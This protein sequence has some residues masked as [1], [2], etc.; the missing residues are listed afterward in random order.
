MK[1]RV[2]KRAAM[3][4]SLAAVFPISV[5]AAELKGQ[6]YFD[7]YPYTG[8]ELIFIQNGEQVAVTQTDEFGNYLLQD[9]DPGRYRVRVRS[10]DFNTSQSFADVQDGANIHN[11]WLLNEVDVPVSAKYELSG[12][13][14][15]LNGRV[16]PN[17]EIRLN[18]NDGFGTTSIYTDEDGYYS[19]SIE[20][21]SYSVE[22]S[23]YGDV[24]IDGDGELDQYLNL[25]ENGEQLNLSAPTTRDFVFQVKEVDIKAVYDGQSFSAW[26]VS[27][28][29]YS[30]SLDNDFISGYVYSYVYDTID[31]HAIL[32]A[33]Q[34]I[35]GSL[36]PFDDSL[37]VTSLGALVTTSDATLDSFEVELEDTGYIVDVAITDIDGEP[38]LGACAS[39]RNYDSTINIY[40]CANDQENIA[41]FHVP[42]ANYT[43]NSSN[44][45]RDWMASNA[46]YSHLNLNTIGVLDLSEQPNE[47][48]SLSHDLVLPIYKQRGRVV[49][50]EGN[51]IEGAQISYDVYSWFE[52]N[53]FDSYVNARLDGLS[54]NANGI[55][56]VYV[57]FELD[58]MYVSAPSDSGLMGGYFEYSSSRKDKLFNIVLSES[59]SEEPDPEPGEGVFV[60]GKV[61]NI[62]GEP[63]SMNVNVYDINYDIVNSTTSDSNGNYSVSVPDNSEYRIDVSYKNYW[64]AASA[65]SSNYVNS[66]SELFTV[67]G[68]SKQDIVIPVL[69]SSFR[70]VGADGVAIPGMQIEVRGNSYPSGIDYSYSRHTGV[71]NNEGLVTIA[72][73]IQYVSTTINN[74]PLP[75]YEDMYRESEESTNTHTD[76]IYLGT[77]VVP[78]SDEDGI[79][80]FYEERFGYDDAS[81]DYDGDGLTFLEEYQNMSSPFSADTDTDGILDVDDTNSQLFKGIGDVDTSLD[82]D[83]DGWGDVYEIMQGLDPFDENIKPLLLSN[84][85]LNNEGLESCLIDSIDEW[86]NRDAV[87]A[88]EIGS[89]SCWDFDLSSLSGIENFVNLSTLRLSY[90][91]EIEDFSALSKLK[92]LVSLSITQ[93]GLS[94]LDFLSELKALN[95][96]NITLDEYAGDL[97]GLAELN[98]LQ[99]LAITLGSYDGDLS[100]IGT[101]GQL[102][103]LRLA[104]GYNVE[105]IDFLFNLTELKSLTLQ[106]FPLISEELEKLAS[107]EKLENLMLGST[108]VTS[109]D[110]IV[111]LQNLR[112]FD[113]C[114]QSGVDFSVLSQ[115]PSLKWLYISNSGL[116]D[117]SFL[118]GMELEGLG[119]WDNEIVD[120]SPLA[121]MESLLY[122]YLGGN[123]DLT[124]LEDADWELNYFSLE[125]Y[126]PFTELDTDGDGL[127]DSIDEDDD[128]DGIPD[129]DDINPLDFDASIIDSIHLSHV[130]DM[131]ED[132][133]AVIKQVSMEG[134]LQ[135]DIYDRYMDEKLSAVSWPIVYA[136]QQVISFDDIDGDGYPEL[137]L[138]GIIET[139]LE[140]GSIRGKPQLRIHDAITNARLNVYN[141]PANWSD[142]K[143]VKLDDLTGDGVSDFALQGLFKD[144]DRPQ[145]MVVDA[146]TGDSVAKYSYPN[147]QDSPIYHQLSD[148]DGDG[149]GEIGLFGRLLSN[150]K[151]Q[152]KVTSGT[153][154]SDKLPAY[155]FPDNW[156]QVSWHRLHDIDF[157]GLTDFG[158][159][160]KNREDGRWQLFTKS[161]A[162]RVG[163]LG[164]YAWPNDLVDV[165]L[166]SIPDMN[167]DGVPELGVFGLRTSSDRYQLIVKDGT[168]RAST[169]VNMGWPNNATFVSVHVMHDIDLDGLPEVGLLAQRANGSYFISVRD[170]NGGNSGNFELGDD[171]NSAPIILTIPGD[172][173]SLAPTSAAFGNSAVGN[174]KAYGF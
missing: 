97:S 10:S 168:D 166:I 3:L 154:D 164:I 50:E 89:L 4:S 36:T 88:H 148:M 52:Y 21:G 44:Y 107:L 106:N 139:E 169:L 136:D 146:V 62:L 110:W 103:D 74:G 170:G 26:L 25:N 27:N 92:R 105:K 70:V 2:F 8:A 81:F 29:S 86:N 114:C 90:D 112:S 123:S 124:C 132:R 157:D 135:V 9:I 41:T 129:I 80:D 87:Y 23:F 67:S 57:P 150:N 71:T 56:E 11:V 20:Q 160:G 83:N 159:F 14:T 37:F 125:L 48:V 5:Q 127:A 119:L 115:L 163:G 104:D 38:L 43:I 151:A 122:I 153:D 158:L 76:I 91:S 78:D 84:L 162:T 24:D 16:Y 53:G 144:G 94:S 69:S 58:E 118:Q 40:Q 31:T 59:G 34:V 96:L 161:G 15:D 149:V 19:S 116:T 63:L 46:D 101:L 142:M 130:S 55:F 109:L 47:N 100:V 173:N 42:S 32:P 138:F 45:R 99:F 113:V 54:T 126:C 49:D 137:G 6:V 140:D 121:G 17:A 28:Q 111:A 61:T 82:S 120:L 75:V 117:I 128:N 134:E 131:T 98:N 35:S 12:Q 155:N 174:E 108:P 60:S 152:I 1:S 7:Y 66:R 30:Y 39:L 65:Y 143:I 133:I 147:I 13:L 145:L 51:R 172:N 18:S 79:P 156:E 77:F 141:W 95:D 167:F 72:A 165:Q 171:W 22:Y 85:D 102:Y 68:D 73:P 33:G 93:P 64:T